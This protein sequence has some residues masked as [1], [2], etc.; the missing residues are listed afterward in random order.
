MK[1]NRLIRLTLF[2]M[3]VILLSTYGFAASW[4]RAAEATVTSIFVPLE[5][6]VTLSNG[7]VVTFSGQVHVHAGHLF[8][9]L[10]ADGKH[11]R[12]SHRHRR[13]ER[14]VG[15]HVS[16]CGR[17]RILTFEAKPLES[18]GGHQRNL[19]RYECD[20]TKH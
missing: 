15:S 5:E 17:V 8:G 2:L 18:S 20:K 1:R 7:D 10:R 19:P 6:D 11:V 12:Q 14:N 9:S 16:P 4:A 13:N 3:A